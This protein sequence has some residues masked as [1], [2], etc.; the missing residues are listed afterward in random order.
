MRRGGEKMLDDLDLA[1]EE[2]ESGRRRGGPPTRQVRQ[3]RRKEKKR[4]R[5]SFGALFIS[6]LLLVILGGGVYWGVGKAQEFL[7]APDYVGNPA[8]VPVSVTIDKGDIASVI[9]SKLYDK[10]VVKSVKAYT[11][12]VAA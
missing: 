5:R 1:W 9:G 6:L 8:K 4:R 7:G 12:A 2:Q 10:K 11:K 3:R